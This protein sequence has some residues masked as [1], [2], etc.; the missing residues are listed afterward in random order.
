MTRR[1]TCPART[2]QLTGGHA[3]ETRESSMHLKPGETVTARDLLRAILMRSANDGC[4]AAGERIAGSESAFV[5]LMNRRA[6][7][8]GDAKK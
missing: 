1:E 8:L 5:A 2:S 7:E 6:K 4:V 3:S